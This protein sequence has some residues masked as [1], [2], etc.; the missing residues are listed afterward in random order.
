LV[1]LENSSEYIIFYRYDFCN[2]L[3]ENIKLQCLKNK[4]LT[5]ISV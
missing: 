4:G 2:I 1:M 5:Y 3:Y